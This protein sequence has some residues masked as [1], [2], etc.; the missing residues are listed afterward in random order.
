MIARIK[1]WLWDSGKVNQKCP[2]HLGWMLFGYV[3]GV[4]LM[5]MISL[6]IVLTKSNCP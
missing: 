4:G 5:G 6:I 2:G 3:L 1:W